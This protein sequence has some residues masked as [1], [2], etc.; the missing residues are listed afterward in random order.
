ML[1]ARDTQP[2]LD[3]G[4]FGELP[5]CLVELP[6]GPQEVPFEDQVGLVDFLPLER[7]VQPRTADAPHRF[8]VHD[9]SSS[10]A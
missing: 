9:V 2:F 7:G 8:F 3:L 4:G 5:G 1:A 10:N 6:L